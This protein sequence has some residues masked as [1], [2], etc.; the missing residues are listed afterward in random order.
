MRQEGF[1]SKLEVF[2]CLNQ[3]FRNSVERHEDCFFA[4]CVICQ[5][6]M[7]LVSPLFEV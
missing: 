3:P 4:V 6:D 5:Y 7:E 1:H 2:G